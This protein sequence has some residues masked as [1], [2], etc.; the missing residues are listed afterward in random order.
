[1]KKLKLYAAGGAGCNIAASFIKN[2]KQPA[3][4][5]AE[6]DC[7]FIDTSKSNLNPSIP[8]DQIYLFDSLDGSGKLRASNYQVLNEHS[9]E[10]LLEHKPGDVNIILS[11]AGGGS[12]SVIAPIL[13]SELLDRGETVI[14]ITVGSTSSRIETE[15][16]LKTLRSYEVISQKR[17]V[18]V[19][20]NYV[21]NSVQRPRGVN[22]GDLHM[23]ISILAAIFSGNN[24]E[25]DGSDLKNFLNYH[26]VTNYSP[27]LAMLEFF[28]KEIVMPKGQAMV[29]LVSLIDDSTS[30]DVGVLA[31]Y[32]AVGYVPESVKE[33]LRQDVPIHAAVI[34]G[35]FNGV[36]ERLEAKIASYDDVR[37]AVIEKSIAGRDTVSTDDGIVL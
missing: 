23:I 6:V 28:H 26:K 3:H 36:V 12:G 8:A 7:V 32:Q 25:L 11:S 5:F 31:E 37:K 29:S 19:I 1:M 27:K 4:G 30:S 16:T 35:Y 34:S 10:I 14:V 20:M 15:N 33:T 17:G 9:R 24:R 2:F 22:D 13:V 21:E 18:P